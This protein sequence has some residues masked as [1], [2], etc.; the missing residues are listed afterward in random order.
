MWPSIVIIS[1]EKFED[2]KGEIRSCI[3][4]ERQW[5]G[6][7]KKDKRTNNDLQ[8]GKQKLKIEQHETNK[9]RKD[10]NQ[11]QTERLGA[12]SHSF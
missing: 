9:N 10:V 8:N 11:L 1:E 4:N 12:I 5:I 7:K 3:S 2:T 6:Q